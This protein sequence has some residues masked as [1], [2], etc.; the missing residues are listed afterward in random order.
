MLLFVEIEMSQAAC[1]SLHIPRSAIEL[2]PSERIPSTE[3]AGT[4]HNS[5]RL[6]LI[7]NE[8]FTILSHLVR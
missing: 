3:L 1:S 2:E 4:N 7:D 8:T 5:L 6:P